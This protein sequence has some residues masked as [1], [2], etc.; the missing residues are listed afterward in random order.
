VNL[1][2]AWRTLGIA[3]TQDNRAIR[4]AYATRLKALDVDIERDSF[5]A[6]REA[7][8]MALAWASAKQDSSEPDV[9][10]HAN[11]VVVD[12]NA[13][14]DSGF[15]NPPVISS[16]GSSAALVSTHA[17]VETFRLPAIAANFFEAQT[18]ATEPV[19]MPHV[20]WHTVMVPHHDAPS[21]PTID[22]SAFGS[23]KND[24]HALYTLLFP[25]GEEAEQ[26]LSSDQAEFALGSLSRLLGSVRDG[27]IA[28]QTRMEQWISEV[29]ARSWPRSAPLLSTA[30]NF[31]NWRAADGQI[32]VPP[33]IEYLNKRLSAQQFLM[34]VQSKK[35]RLH[36][37]WKQLTKPTRPGQSRALW[38]EGAKIQELLATV[39]ADY[40]ELESHFDWDR[41]ALWETR[42]QKPIKSY[43]WV[44][45]VAMSLQM[46]S[47]V[48]R[49][50][51]SSETEND[52][53]ASAYSQNAYENE[54]S[55]VNPDP[56]PGALTSR[57][58][59]IKL[60]LDQTTGAQLTEE[61]LSTVN[62]DLYRTLHSNWSIALENHRKRADFVKDM[63]A[64][65]VERYIRRAR[66]TGG[67]E[68]IKLQR[69]RLKGAQFLSDGR[70]QDCVNLLISDRM[71]D[72]TELP[73]T[74]QDTLQK[75]IAAVLKSP[76]PGSAYSPTG[77]SYRIPGEIVG[78]V[79]DGSGLEEKVVR[80][81][82]KGNGSP[83]QL[84]LVN[85]ALLKS[86]LNADPKTR[87][88]IL[89]RL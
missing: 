54:E 40:P 58:A 79:I 83:K 67:D 47:L 32:G 49:T 86:V 25:D 77:S 29:L 63:D 64:L 30:A 73:Q 20:I 15:S 81:V 55:T 60:V 19:M 14:V 26:L 6:L 59:D 5:A 17:A 51:S 34:D 66:D 18:T 8:D 24:D 3:A 84:C 87:N 52:S 65:L 2:Q 9:D 22:S 37:S 68:L 39:R 31:F 69:I 88:E 74:V 43:T 38:W 85:T 80:G 62:P 11:H 1:K 12:L 46:L 42:Q 78:Q 23:I 71:P 44:F 48:G 13:T 7:R 75:R 61:M 41:V 27:D 36:R 4:S 53:S 82:F 50:F 70:W 45:I 72:I 28:S 76:P 57:S 33:A 10:E 56:A 89:A 35:H 21:A 16:V